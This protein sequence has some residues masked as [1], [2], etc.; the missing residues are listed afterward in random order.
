MKLNVECLIE[1]GDKPGE[2]GDET[3]IRTFGGKSRE[4][5]LNKAISYIETVDSYKVP[6]ARGDF[7]RATATIIE[8]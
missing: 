5:I 1:W 6:A 3:I 4:H 7:V 2:Y 8:G